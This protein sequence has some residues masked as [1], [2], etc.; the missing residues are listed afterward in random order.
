VAGILQDKETP[1]T[2]RIKL[3][4]RRDMTV[5]ILCLPLLDP[6]TGVV[7]H[8][9]V[10]GSATT[11]DGGAQKAYIVKMWLD[12]LSTVWKAHVLS[13]PPWGI[14]GYVL[15]EGCNVAPNGQ[16]LQQQRQK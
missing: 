2:K 11:L 6:C 12:N 7:G 13:I 9:Y 15:G 14:G 3:T 1:P 5:T 4:T 10:A 16:A 8:T